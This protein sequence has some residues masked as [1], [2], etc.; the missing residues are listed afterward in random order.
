MIIVDSV[1]RMV[2]G[3]LSDASCYEDESIYSGLLEYPQYTRPPVF[4][5]LEVPKVL[6]E[7]NHKLIEAWKKE[8]SLAITKERR[9][10]LYTK[11]MN[12]KAVRL[13]EEKK[14]KKELQKLRYSK[15]K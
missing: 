5:G 3:V 4:K 14:R 12:R 2:E 6:Q 8:Q 10:D 7:G 1:S 13:E 11:Y 9:K 15:K